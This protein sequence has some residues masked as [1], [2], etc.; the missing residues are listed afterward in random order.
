MQITPRVS[1]SLNYILQTK[2]IA[3]IIFFVTIGEVNA[4][5]LAIVFIGNSITRAKAARMD[6]LRQ[7]IRSII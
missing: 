3:V 4:Q 2:V 1:K 6:F 7:L 5:N